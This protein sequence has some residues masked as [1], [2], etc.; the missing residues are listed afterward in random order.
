MDQPEIALPF[1]T[2]LIRKHVWP[3]GYARL[4][5]TTW[6]DIRNGGALTIH[7]GLSS[8]EHFPPSPPMS[9]WPDIRTAIKKLNEL[10]ARE[11]PEHVC[12]DECMRDFH[13]MALQPPTDLVQ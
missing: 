9:D 3:G 6:P 8:T 4:T 2:T 12:G 5:V 13:E 7:A 1:P 11:F 10:F